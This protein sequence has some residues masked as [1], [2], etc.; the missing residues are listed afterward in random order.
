MLTIHYY[1][2]TTTVV[3]VQGGTEIEKRKLVVFVNLL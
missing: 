3:Q 1:L 2:G